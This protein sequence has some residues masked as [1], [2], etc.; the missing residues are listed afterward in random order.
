M[1]K[2]AD[3][4]GRKHERGN[5]C[6]LAVG[7]ALAW[8][9]LTSSSRWWK[10]HGRKTMKYVVLC[11]F[12]SAAIAVG[13]DRAEPGYP[14][15]V[16]GEDTMTGEF[17]FV[18]KIIFN[19]S[20]VGCTGSLIAPD[21]VLTAGHCVDRYRLT[22]LSVGFGDTRTVEPRYSVARKILHPEYSAQENDI[23]ILQLES[24]VAIQPVRILTLEE[25]LQYAPSGTTSGVAVG[26]G[27]TE[28]AGRGGELPET[29]QKITDI[30]IYTEEDCRRA[31]DDLRSQGK[32]P[33]PPSIH[34]RVLCAG[35]ENRAIGQGDSGGPLLIQT[36]DGWGQVGVLSQG[37]ADPSPQTVIY[38]GQ[39]TRT[40]YFLDWI[41]TAAPRAA[42][43]LLV[44]NF[45]NGNNGAFNSTGLFVESLD[46]RRAGYG[47]G[48]HTAPD[49]RHSPGADRSTTGFGNPGST[50]GT[51]PQTGRRYPHPPGD[52]TALY[53]RRG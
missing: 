48:F 49:H 45:S 26:W 14:Q 1:R 39:Y 37:T 52:H 34:E 21:K 47:A 25:E 20:H 30:P 28:Q 35:E 11:A 17:P 51:Q 46:K 29:L 13:Q 12:F 18:A 16:G 9:I 42:V 31:L 36:P 5:T 3:L 23:A 53:D 2:W 43:T 10:S 24:A 27:Y 19:G 4:I 6:H 44:A 40:S 22:R 33:Q 8:Q 50:I 41:Y 38:M 15:I 32:K 7:V